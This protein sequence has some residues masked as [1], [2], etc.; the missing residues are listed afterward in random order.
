MAADNQWRSM[1]INQRRSPGD[2]L[3]NHPV[4]SKLW[5]CCPGPGAELWQAI[6]ASLSVLRCYMLLLSD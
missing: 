5:N 6:A 3:K 4:S 1:A 2:Y